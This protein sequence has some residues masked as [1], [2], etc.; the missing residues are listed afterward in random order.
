M[1]TKNQV[2][3]SSTDKSKVPPKPSP[4]C[5]IEAALYLGFPLSSQ[6][7]APS[8]VRRAKSATNGGRGGRRGAAPRPLRLVVCAARK[9]QRM[10]GTAPTC[11]VRLVVCTARKARRMGGAWAPAPRP[12]AYLGAFPANWGHQ[13]PVLWP[14]HQA[15]SAWQLLLSHLSCAPRFQRGG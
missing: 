11:S 5:T 3:M 9:A 8:R 15:Q 10:G 7:C 4:P 6:F 12:L 14:S 1:P 13:P 2:A